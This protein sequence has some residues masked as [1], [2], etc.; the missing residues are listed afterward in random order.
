MIIHF[1]KGD[2]I[3][4]TIEIWGATAVVPFHGKSIR[5]IVRVLFQNSQLF[6]LEMLDPSIQLHKIDSDVIMSWED[7]KELMKGEVPAITDK[8]AE[9]LIRRFWSSWAKEL[10]NI[11]R[12]LQPKKPSIL[13]KI[14]R[15]RYFRG[16]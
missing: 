2:V 12:V 7:A 9:R 4:L 11:Q 16:I 6:C 15:Y 8:K 5:G 14:S 3:F 13:D 1:E 10:D